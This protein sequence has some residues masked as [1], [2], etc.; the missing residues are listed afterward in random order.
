MS[1]DAWMQET[2]EMLKEL[3]QLVPMWQQQYYHLRCYLQNGWKH[4]TQATKEK[5]LTE[6]IECIKFTIQNLP[7]LQNH[8]INN[9]MRVDV[10]LYKELTQLGSV[11]Y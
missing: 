9:F 7:T 10:T 4:T 3:E 5:R 11:K 6:W 8:L 1:Q 2:I